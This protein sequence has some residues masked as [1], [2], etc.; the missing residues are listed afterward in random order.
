MGHLRQTD[1]QETPRKHTQPPYTTNYP[2]LD[3]K[4]DVENDVR[5]KGKVNAG[6]LVEDMHGAE[7]M[8]RHLSFFANAA[9]EEQ[10]PL[11]K[12]KPELL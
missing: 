1:K 11:C 7:Q 5:K 9:T 6:E 2:R 12:E 3:G 4:I 10:N 8:G